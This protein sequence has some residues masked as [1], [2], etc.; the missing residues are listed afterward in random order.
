MEKVRANLFA[1]HSSDQLLLHSHNF[2][3]KINGCRDFLFA[4]QDYVKMGETVQDYRK[5]KMDFM[6]LQVSPMKVYSNP[7]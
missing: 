5:F 3:T 4:V 6:L 1:K 2:S 7:D